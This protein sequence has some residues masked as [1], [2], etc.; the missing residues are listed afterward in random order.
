MRAVRSQLRRQRRPRHRPA[1]PRRWS[2]ASPSTSRRCRGCRGGPT[3]RRAPTPQPWSHDPADAAERFMRRLIGDARWER[4][5]SATR[6]ARRSEGPA[7]VGELDRPS[8][9]CAVVAR[10]RS[11][12][13]CCR[14][15][16]NSCQEHHRRAALTVQG[17][18]GCD[19]GHHPRRP[20][21]RPQHPSGRGRRVLTDFASSAF[22]RQARE[23]RRHHGERGG[24]GRHHHRTGHPERLVELAGCD[25]RRPSAPASRSCC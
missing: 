21:L 16:A 9:A 2:A 11:P 18:F 1:T 19:R 3:R 25:D 10:A 7:L 5:P 15:A 24:G 20:S 4:L 13:P 12:L 14:F 23:R 17:W 22:R 6:E 8:P